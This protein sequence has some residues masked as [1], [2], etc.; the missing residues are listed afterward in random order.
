MSRRLLEF[1]VLA[2]AMGVAYNVLEG[3]TDAW[4][5]LLVF[6]FGGIVLGYVSL[7]LWVLAI[8][9]LAG[10]L[11]NAAWHLLHWTD[12]SAVELPLPLVLLLGLIVGACGIPAA[13]LGRYA[14][15]RSDNLAGRA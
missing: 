6:V 7:S 2:L 4:P 8:C 12:E 3:Q 11:G 5:A 9:P 13:L 14:A 1:V 10:M 15:G